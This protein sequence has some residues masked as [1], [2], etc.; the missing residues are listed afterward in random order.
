MK[1]II[2]GIVGLLLVVG[3]VWYL[4]VNQKPTEGIVEDSRPEQSTDSEHDQSYAEKDK[5]QSSNNDTAPSLSADST[6]SDVDNSESVSE[7]DYAFDESEESDYSEPVD[8]EDFA[9]FVNAALEELESDEVMATAIVSEMSKILEAQP[10]LE[11]E[12]IRFYR[13][14]TEKQK[15]SEAVKTK[16]REELK[17]RGAD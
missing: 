17:R 14:C 11:E 6:D 3:V 4:V 12:G 1:K 7:E 16:C 10:A 5:P 13:K 2:L 15:I 9:D 8:K